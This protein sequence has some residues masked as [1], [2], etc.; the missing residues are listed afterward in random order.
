MYLNGR[1]VPASAARISPY[2]RGL[3]LGD[4]V[5]ETLRAY[6]GCVFRLDR[7]LD[8]LRTSLRGIRAEWTFSRDEVAAAM[9]ELLQANSLSDARIRLTVTGGEFDG[10]LR[11][12]RSNP[13]TVLITA[14]PLTIPS[15]GEYARGIALRT[16]SMR[17][18]W[19]SP[20][21][22]IKTIHRLEYLMAR[23]EAIEQGADDALILDDR[24]GVAE[25]SACNVFLVTGKGVAT[26]SLDGPILPGVTREAAIEAARAAGLSVEERFVPAEE[27]ASAEEIFVT[28]TSWEVLS[29]NSVDGLNI[30]SGGRGPV[31]AA[32]H[33][34]FRKL[35]R[36]ECGGDPPEPRPEPTS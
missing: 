34:S 9:R 12:A 32:I 33:E 20:L 14:G 4:G 25:G 35:V 36:S 13:S 29:V 15:P 17:Q 1:I 5:F 24:G 3:L 2:D 7:H 18:P 23:E 6:S 31:T 10:R 30:R 19:N 8:R 11:L 16:A 21:A 22:R 26:P 28:A 27:L